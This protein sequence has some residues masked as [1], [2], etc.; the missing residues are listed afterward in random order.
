MKIQENVDLK[1]YTTMQLEAR[2]KYFIE[3][4]S[5][6]DLRDA[7]DFAKRKKLDWFVLG[8]GSNLIANADFNGVIFYSKIRGFS[9]IGN[10]KYRLGAGEIADEIIEK[11]CEKQLSG[12]ECLSLIPGTIGA[13]PVQN[14]G[15]YGQEIADVFI[16]ATVF[17]FRSN[18]FKVL[19]RDDLKFAYRNSIL[20]ARKNRNYII[21]DITV[22]LKEEN[23]Q[24]PF[25]ASL[26]KYLRENKIF[27][28]SPLSIRRAVIEIR[29]QKLPPVEK[30]ASAGS[31][32]K[33]PIISEKIAKKILEKF[34]EMP[35]WSLQNG[36][37]KLAAGWLIERSGLYSFK[38]FGF[39][40]YPKNSLVITN[41]ASSDAAELE[42]FKQEIVKA[43]YQRFA[44][45][46][47][48]E[49]ENLVEK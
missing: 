4:N 33:N 16:E 24:P 47:E 6:E 45:E 26:E 46:L 42:K 2:A 10:L 7:A 30:I 21:T 12:M 29:N 22:Q 3:I 37:E 1:K 11:F 41:I 9:E 17:D 18:S 14:V 13:M 28:Y 5:T 8:G 39:Q 31:F 40:L 43:V 32:F 23:L 27:D 44:I 38:K 15:A 35:H 19:T 34:P 49:P 20:K 25:Y 36:C 48:Q